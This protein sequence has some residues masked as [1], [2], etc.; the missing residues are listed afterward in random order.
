[1]GEESFILRNVPPILP[2][3]PAVGSLMAVKLHV[4]FFGC[5]NEL[6]VSPKKPAF[7]GPT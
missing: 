3:Y 2:Q 6:E 7:A 4:G 1:M 5:A